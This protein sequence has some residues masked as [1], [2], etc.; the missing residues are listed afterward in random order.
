MYNPSVRGLSAPPQANISVECCIIQ[1]IDKH[2]FN[3]G[4]TPLLGT[5]FFCLFFPFFQHFNSKSDQLDNRAIILE[6]IKKIQGSGVPL[7]T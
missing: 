7:I 6:A 4:E 3:A 5:F 2:W 1:L